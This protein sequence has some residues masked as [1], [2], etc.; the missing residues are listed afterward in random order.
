MAPPPAT[1]AATTAAA[2]TRAR[3]TRT[4]TTQRYS[5]GHPRDRA[6]RREPHG[7]YARAIF[8]NPQ[9]F[10]G[11]A[12]LDVGCGSGVLSMFAARAGARKGGIDCSSI[13][14]SARQNVELNGLSTW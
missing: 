4:R 1:T 13:L 2:T 11:K 6:A 14:F 9:L 8:D 3:R 10:E 5:H 12:V 7:G